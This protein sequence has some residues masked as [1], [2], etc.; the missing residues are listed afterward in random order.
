MC[1]IL[2]LFLL[3]SDFHA[4]SAPGISLTLLSTVTVLITEA[5]IT[6]R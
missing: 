1:E 4:S 2:V 3:G 6:L 5:I